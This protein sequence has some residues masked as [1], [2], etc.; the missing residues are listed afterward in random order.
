MIIYSF[1]FFLLLEILC[2]I[3]YQLNKEHQTQPAKGKGFRTAQS[4]AT[5][6]IVRQRWQTGFLLFCC[7]PHPSIHSFG[8]IG[9][10]RARLGRG[11]DA[12]DRGLVVVALR[13]LG[14]RL[15]LTAA[16][17]DEQDHGDAENVKPSKSI[18]MI[19]SNTKNSQSESHRTTNGRIVVVLQMLSFTFFA[20]W[21]I[22]WVLRVNGR[23]TWKNP[24]IQNPELTPSA[25]AKLTS[26]DISRSARSKQLKDALWSIVLGM[27]TSELNRQRGGRRVEVVLSW[28]RTIDWEVMMSCGGMKRFYRWIGVPKKFL[29]SF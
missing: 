10:C 8:P 18:Q 15:L 12:F 5:I 13:S 25:T 27:T 7:L 4:K 14:S 11:S 9:L 1:A 28:R 17:L 26:V 16:H 20:F 19:I 24:I 21:F 22:S 6:F 29:I 23:K 3:L 2:F